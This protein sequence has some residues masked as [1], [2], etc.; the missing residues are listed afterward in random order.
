MSC[1]MTLLLPLHWSGRLEWEECQPKLTT[2]GT[3]R[4]KGNKHKF[5]SKTCTLKFIYN[6]TYLNILATLNVNQSSKFGKEGA[7]VLL[8]EKNILVLIIRQY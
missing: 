8:I 7:K 1:D 4:E 3:L 6:Y 5:T 2:F